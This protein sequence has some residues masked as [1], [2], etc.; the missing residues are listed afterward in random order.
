MLT[1]WRATAIAGQLTICIQVRSDLT[2]SVYVAGRPS[3]IDYDKYTTRE[4]AQ[5]LLGCGDAGAN[6]I[7]GL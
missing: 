5:G 6:K 7:N 3:G 2:P 1:T 4:E